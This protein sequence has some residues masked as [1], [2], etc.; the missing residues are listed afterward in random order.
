MSIDI[1]KAAAYNQRKASKPFLCQSTR[2]VINPTTPAGVHWVAKQ[3]NSLDDDSWSKKGKPWY[4]PSKRIDVDGM[5][6]PT[7][8]RELV[9]RYGPFSTEPHTLHPLPWFISVDRYDLAREPDDLSY[10]QKDTDWEQFTSHGGWYDA[11]LRLV[12]GWKEKRGTFSRVPKDWISL[13][14]LSIGIAHYWADTAPKFLAGFANALPELSGEAWGDRAEKMAD[15]EWV[16][17]QIRVM[18]GRRPH[19]A[20]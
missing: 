13:D 17:K 19:Q 12:S 20:R 8:Q 6:G 1:H 3:Q 10:K 15:P 16:R 18:T 14:E 11:M 7:T 2:R 9:S 5:L 4:D